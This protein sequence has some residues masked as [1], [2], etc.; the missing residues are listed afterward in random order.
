LID[1]KILVCP[2]EGENNDNNSIIL[3]NSFLIVCII[4]VAFKNVMVY[5]C[6]LMILYFKCFRDHDS[7]FND[8]VLIRWYIN[9]LSLPNLHGSLLFNYLAKAISKIFIY[10]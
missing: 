2:L 5:G 1:T 4:C 7:I 6:I 8:I 9:I 10:P 3:N